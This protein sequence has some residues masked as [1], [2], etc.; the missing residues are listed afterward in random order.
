MKKE[1]CVALINIME[2]KNRLKD[3]EMQPVY[4]CGCYDSMG[5]FKKQEFYSGLTEE[6]AVL[7]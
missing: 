1:E 3:T 6:K 4:F 2:F 7:A 5:Y